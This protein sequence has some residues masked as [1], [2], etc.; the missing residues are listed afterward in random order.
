MSK[1]LFGIVVLFVLL[2]TTPL[3]ANEFQRS[4]IGRW[5]VEFANGV[6]Q[7]CEIRMDETASELRKFIDPRYL[8][9]HKLDVG[10]FPIR[11]VVTGA[12]YDNSPCDEPQT[13]LV[14]VETEEAE[15][16]VWRLRMTTYEG[17]SYILPPSPPD[18]TTRAFKPW[19]TRRKL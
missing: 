16:E 2:S 11:R 3:P 12:I 4:L 5:T 1:A 6:T 14:V 13:V 8:K 19:T 7:W 18:A 10:P 15:Q 9:E 17:N